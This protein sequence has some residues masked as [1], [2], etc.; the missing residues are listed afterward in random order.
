[1]RRFW[2][3]ASSCEI[4]LPPR[5]GGATLPAMSKLRIRV[6]LAAV[7]VVLLLCVALPA[8]TV[9]PARTAPPEPVVEITAEPS[10]HLIAENE[11]ARWFR[12]QVAPHAETLMHRHE[13]DY[14]YVVIGAAAVEN[15]VSGGS[16]TP[17]K[18]ADGEVRFKA[19]GFAHAARDLSATPFRN[20]TIELRQKGSAAAVADAAWH[21][22]VPGVSRRVVM[23]QDGVRVTELRLASGATIPMHH[24]DN[25]H[26]VV[27]LTETELTSTTPAASAVIRQKP[28]DTAWVKAGLTHSL[29]NS[30]PSEARFLTFEWQ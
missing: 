17:L 20:V 22:I 8:Q 27:A 10:H 1:M 2:W 21:D 28:G 6:L 19:G 25:P 5:R 3:F 30:G 23:M 13:L 16:T 12:V 18:F 15:H 11:Y 7:Q 24:H 4:G 14:F 26:L 9:A 29:Q